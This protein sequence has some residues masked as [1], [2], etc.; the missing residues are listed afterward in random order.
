MPG[1]GNLDRFPVMV[2]GTLTTFRRRCGKSS[3][4]CASGERHETPALMYR[5]GG[6]TRIVTLSQEDAPGVAAALDRYQ[7]ARAELE[8]AADEGIAA[9]RARRAGTR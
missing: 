9:L 3:C 8:A 4:R 1:I 5:D 6:K 7:R 2:R